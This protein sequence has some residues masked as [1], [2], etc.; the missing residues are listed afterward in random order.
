MGG[1][2]AGVLARMGLHRVNLVDCLKHLTD[3]WPVR[4]EALD[5][6]DLAQRALPIFQI[7]VQDEVPQM[8]GDILRRPMLL[9]CGT[10]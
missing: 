10:L 8:P 5:E 1:L 4:A 7:P 2:G 6:V 3:G 9:D